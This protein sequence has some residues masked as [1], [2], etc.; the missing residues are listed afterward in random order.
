MNVPD[1]TKPKRR[2][3]QFR[4]KTIFVIVALHCVPLAWLGVRL[5]QK[6]KERMAVAAIQEFDCLVGY[7]WQGHVVNGSWAFTLPR[8]PTVVPSGPRWLRQFLGDDFFSHAVFVHFFPRRQVF[9]TALTKRDIWTVYRDLDATVF[10]RLGELTTL[11]EVVLD[12]SPVT[13]ADLIHFRS[14]TN[15]RK[16]RVKSTK[17]SAAGVD[18][19]QKALPNCK[20]EWDASAKRRLVSTPRINP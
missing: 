11:E 5:N 10:L 13:D 16:L 8:K 18:A 3:L 4:L 19:L 17:V 1:K 6:R 7:D 12:E 9:V 2:W 14:L 20:I 15:L